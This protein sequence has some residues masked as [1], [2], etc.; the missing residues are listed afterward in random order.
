[1]FSSCSPVMLASNRLIMSFAYILH[2]RCLRIS[3]C[4]HALFRVENRP[5]E[6]A[7]ASGIAMRPCVCVCVYIYTLDARAGIGERDGPCVCVHAS[8]MPRPCKSKGK[9][10]RNICTFIR[11]RHIIHIYVRTWSASTLCPFLLCSFSLSPSHF[12]FPRF[13]VPRSPFLYRSC[14]VSDVYT[15]TCCVYA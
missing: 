1:M 5:G 9:R 6:K 14:C 7:R 4:T 8:G 10:K 3:S 12:Y 2:T 15:Y 11:D 13:T